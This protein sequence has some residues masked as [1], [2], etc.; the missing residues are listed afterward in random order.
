MTPP[1]FI[2]IF[3]FKN[4][5]NG[6]TLSVK[7]NKSDS[8]SRNIK[9]CVPLGRLII[10]WLFNL[11][12]NDIRITKILLALYMDDTAIM[13]RNRS[14][15]IVIKQLLSYIQVIFVSLSKW[16]MQQKVQP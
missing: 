1:Q 13:Y 10:K 6:R 9:A 5:L 12:I 4:Y 14:L 16:R 7:L 15:R 11:Y 8:S 2:F 3:I